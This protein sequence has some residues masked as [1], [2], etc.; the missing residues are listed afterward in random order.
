MDILSIL[1]ISSIRIWNIEK[2][3][4]NCIITVMSRELDNRSL[5]SAVLTGACRYGGDEG[6]QQILSG[7]SQ[8]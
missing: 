8:S 5:S 3:G 7:L 4:H 2:P 1:Y 6:R